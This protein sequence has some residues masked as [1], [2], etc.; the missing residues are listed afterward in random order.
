DPNQTVDPNPNESWWLHTGTP[1][2]RANRITFNGNTDTWAMNIGNT[3]YQ[4]KWASNVIAEAKNNGWDGVFLDNTNSTIYYH[5][6]PW[7]DGREL[8]SD[9]TYSAATKAA[10]ANIGPKLTQAGLLAMPNICCNADNPGSP[11]WNS[12]IQYTSGGF[13]ESFPRPGPAEWAVQL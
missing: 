6:T 11:F 9:S 3:T 4:N 10:L 2:S 8:P 1:A 12:W 5:H 13:D 7:T